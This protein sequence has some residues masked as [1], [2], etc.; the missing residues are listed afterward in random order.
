MDRMINPVEWSKRA[1][2]YEVNIRQFTPEGTLNAFREHIPRLHAMGV[3]TIWIMPVQPIGKV[4]RKG[5]LGSYYSI[6]DYTAMNPEFGNLGD[7]CALVNDTHQLGM[8]VL[9]D[10][11]ANHTAWDHVWTKSHPEF[12]RHDENNHFE[13][14]WDWT[15]VIALDYNNREMRQHMIDAMAFW[16]KETGI[17]GFRCDM[18][19]MV[20]VDFW[21]EARQILDPDRKLFMLAEDE[22]MLEL[23][24]E[25]FDMN[26]TWEMHH[27]MNA[28]ARGERTAS[29][30]WGK[31]HEYTV[32]Y[33]PF[34]YRMYFTSNHDENS[35]SGS[36]VERL[37]DVAPAFSVLT[38]LLP[39]M[40]L[41][42]SGQE[43][44]NRNRIPFFE[45]AAID[46]SS[47]P[48]EKLYKT[49]NETKRDNK[50]LWC[51]PFGGDMV[52]LNQD[53]NDKV[54]AAKRELG[55]NLLIGVLN[56]SNESQQ[57]T[58]DHDRLAG[59]YRD[60]FT[61]EDY[62]PGL[63]FTFELEPWS[64]VLLVRQA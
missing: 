56:L 18:A 11:V 5:S 62:Y 44:A 60:V 19:G 16:L 45:K 61:G 2:L 49:L 14:P 36:T 32:R 41:T 53:Q 31:Y 38:Y 12:Y 64:Y 4:N 20:P 40:P 57:F 34:A 7:F 22:N 58:M 37:G 10:W 21:E 42:Y 63:G 9:L 46:W 28:V 47:L 54:F 15:D 33:S 26:F 29:D 39:G 13:S 43:T 23:L 52:N 59:K 55:D 51:G 30:I 3:D 24:N 35:H 50:A 6:S 8:K 25:A 48:F 27:L 1:N 17:D